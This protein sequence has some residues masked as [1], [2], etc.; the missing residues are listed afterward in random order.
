MS[1][2]DEIAKEIAETLFDQTVRA[3]SFGLDKAE[4][5]GKET[6]RTAKKGVSSIQGHVSD[7]LEITRLAD[8]VG[9]ISMDE[10][11]KI[12]GRLSRKCVSFMVGDEDANEYE[13]LLRQH[14]TLYAR[15]DMGTDNFT[16][17]LCLDKD[18]EVLSE[19]AEIMKA[20]RGTRSE[21]P[22][23]VYFSGLVPSLVGT[24]EKISDV[25]LA[26][27]RE[28]A[29]QAGLLFTVVGPKDDH[30]LVYDAANERTVRDILL[31]TAWDLTG[32]DG[33]RIRS[34]IQTRLEGIQTIR[35][36]AKEYHGDLIV[37]SG[38]N[39][40]NHVLITADSFRIYKNGKTIKSVSRTNPEFEDECVRS[41][42]A[43]SKA[44]VL[45]PDEFTQEMTADDLDGYQTL[46]LYPDY[47]DELGQ[48]TIINR[49][50][51]LISRK[52]ALD[53][54][55][56]ATWGLCDPSVSY[57]EFAGYEELTDEDERQGR[58]Y[59]VAHFKAAAEYGSERLKCSEFV[60]SSSNLD[61]II[62]Q[63][64]IKRKEEISRKMRREERGKSL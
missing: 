19:V 30:T 24:V 9:R 61:R 57:G 44:V 7:H 34:H 56:N 41:C 22:N 15:V 51:S 14:D 62:A 43:L 35:N 58:E 60:S 2:T 21:V 48:Q 54:E 47:Y 27:I 40:S 46:D 55:H 5:I 49:L 37:A 11:N 4:T 28:Q 25:E 12:A 18:S 42:T 1:G 8:T 23:Q 26:L 53:D 52:Y 6:L 29:K 59:E 13:Q 50:A 63:A 33:A 17:F 20:R 32:A 36:A 38:S 64:D 3:A 45:L 39:P 31:H 10:M 16:S